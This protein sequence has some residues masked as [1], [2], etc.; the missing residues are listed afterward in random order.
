VGANA[1]E[2]RRSLSP[3]ARMIAGFVTANLIIVVVAVV[4]WQ[5]RPP[6]PPLIQGVLLPEA[7]PLEEFELLDHQGQAFTNADLRGRWHL[8]S[9]GF[10]TCPDVCPTTLSQLAAMALATISRS[11]TR[12]TS[13]PPSTTTSAPI[14]SAAMIFDASHTL[15]SGATVFNGRLHKDFGM[16]M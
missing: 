2:R 16:D 12:P 5:L 9:Y 10:T 6:A 13:P 4:A 8:V 1:V 11:D 14:S 7:R 3:R 15:A